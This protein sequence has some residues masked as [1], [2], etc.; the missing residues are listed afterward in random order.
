MSKRILLVRSTHGDLNISGYNVQQIG[1]GKAFVDMGYD[2][3]FITFKRDKSKCTE[4]IFYEKNGSKARC[5]EKPRI[6]I[7]RWGIN[8]E[9]C[10]KEFLSQYDLIICQ[11]YYQLQSYLM[12][13]N[14]PNVV[15][16]SGPYYNM[17]LPK[18]ISPFYDLFIGPKLNKLVKVIFVKSILAKDFLEKKGYTGLMNIGVALDTSRFDNVEVA[19][20][21]QKLVSYMQENECILYVGALSDRKNYPFMLE[22]Y[23]KLLEKRPNL[24]FVVIGKSVSSFWHKLFGG[25]DKDYEKK[26]MRLIPENVKKGIMRVQ[27]ID[28]PQLKYVYP[29]TKAFLLPSKL[30]IFGMVLLE[31]LYLGAPVVTSRN[32][33]SLTLMGRSGKY[34]QIVDEF[35]V[36]KWAEAV[37]R[38][39]DDRDYTDSVKLAGQQ[40]VT[41]DFIWNVIAEKMISKCKEVG[42]LK[43][44][45]ISQ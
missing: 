20:D 25:K 30:E 3:D 19:P 6:R 36:D 4:T 14:S 41:E 12:A 15:L 45:K 43:D 18:F 34:G 17:F 2:Y 39:L 5:I 23:T 26:C 11:E 44:R 24:K 29:L 27:R 21:T 31:A 37:M 32:G 42:L 10:Q 33:G 7:L 1:L 38:Y 28:N 16:Y 13:K 8:K 40:R 35:N 9:I 22:L